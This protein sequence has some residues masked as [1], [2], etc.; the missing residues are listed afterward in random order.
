MTRLSASD[1]TCYRG[2]RTVFAGLGFDLE[3]GGLLYL[4]GP[5]GAGKSSLLRILAGLHRP[6][7]GMLSWDGAPIG[8]DGEAHRARLHYVGHQNA[9]KG[10]L[11]VAENLAFWTALRGGGDIAGA[12][13]RGLEAFSLAHLGDLPGRFLSAGQL[14][15]LTLCRLIAA[16][17][18]LWL[19]DEPATALDEAGAGAL[20]AAI[21]AHLA[22][23]GLV[24]LATHE[25]L[26]GDAPILDMVPFAEAAAGKEFPGEEL[27]GE[28]MG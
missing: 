10:A 17:A 15:R 6:R 5:N 12:V 13:A 18:P 7:A 4:R 2:G 24:L 11:T 9:I 1:L 28:E 19:L 3:A 21:Q 27:A 14:R 26:A 23:G 16:P 20:G 22:G 25:R 8:E